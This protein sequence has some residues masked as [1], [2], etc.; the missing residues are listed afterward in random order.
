MMEDAIPTT[1]EGTQVASVPDPEPEA[2]EEPEPE[3]IGDTGE[4]V[5]DPDS[6]PPLPPEP[7]TYD[8][9]DILLERM[10]EADEPSVQVQ[11]QEQVIGVQVER[12]EDLNDELAEIIEE[13]RREK[14]LPEVEPYTSPLE[15]NQ[16]QRQDQDQ[17]QENAPEVE[18]LVVEGQEQVQDQ[19]KH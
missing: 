5:A 15:Q 12:A 10:R 2:D 19:R 7:P 14:G 6:A 8:P 4:A 13:L 17:V 1:V 3:V 11:V 16:E 9:D 18:P